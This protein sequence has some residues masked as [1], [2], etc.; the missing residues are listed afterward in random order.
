MIEPGLYALLAADP[1]IAALVGARIFAGDAPDDITQL[2]CVAYSLVGGSSEA[3]LGTTGVG[4]QR[5][6]ING[7]AMQPSGN[8]TPRD[9]AGQIRAAVIAAVNRWSAL[10]EDGTNVLDTLLVNPGTDFVS[11]QRIFRCVCEFR[12]E[13]TLPPA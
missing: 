13:Y 2:P 12:V 6:E 3:T 9:I 8:L 11:E 1:G 4:W 7:F 5:V 10:L